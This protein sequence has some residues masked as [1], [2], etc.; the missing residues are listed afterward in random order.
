MARD[1]GRLSVNLGVFF[2]RE[3]RI[4]HVYIFHVCEKETTRSRIEIRVRR[5][6][7]SSYVGG[8]LDEDVDGQL[9]ISQDYN[10]H[11]PTPT[12]SL[13]RT[14]FNLSTTTMT[15]NE[16][17][18]ATCLVGKFFSSISRRSLDPD[19]SKNKEESQHPPVRA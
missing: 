9:E 13:V 1:K 8:Y 16:N 3:G 11:P 15:R 2:V 12:A 10:N 4:F 19:S 6:E 7:V 17:F 5:G 18:T 14:L